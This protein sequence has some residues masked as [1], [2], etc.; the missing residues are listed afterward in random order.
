MAVAQ[1]GWCQ[2]MTPHEPV[3]MRQRLTAPRAAGVAGILF[4]MLFGTSIVLLRT[5]LDSQ[6]DSTAAWTGPEAAQIRF[7][8]GLMPYAGIAF[9]WFIGVIRD[10]LGDLE[11]KF[12]ATV[13]LGSG[14]VFI[15]MLF[16]SSAIAGGILAAAQQLDARS[17]LEVTTFARAEML[18]I[19][20]VYALRM[21][22]VFMIS[23][24]TV[25]L[26]TGLMARWTVV[27]TYV[28]ALS[29]LLM[30]TLSL[31]VQL[32]FPAWTL[33]ISTLVLLRSTRSEMHLDH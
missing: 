17:V 16:A 23:L 28:L 8:L 19:T 15:A 9:L 24:G 21:A 14:L 31:W 6:P 27:L 22:G 10:R 1:V 29:L 30:I 5:A 13:F 4:A 33:L 12:F 3:S 25:W 18:E 2:T 20:N 32:I 26:R 11:D 7:A